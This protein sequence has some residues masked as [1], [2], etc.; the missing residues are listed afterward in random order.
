MTY[1][2]TVVPGPITTAQNDGKHLKIKR[3][4]LSPEFSENSGGS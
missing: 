3:N 1:D 2:A 4:P